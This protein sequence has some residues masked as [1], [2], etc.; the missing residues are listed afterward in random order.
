MPRRSPSWPLVWGLTTAALFFAPV[1]MA[2]KSTSQPDSR[3]KASG[4]RPLHRLDSTHL[5]AGRVNPLGLALIS[6]F[7]YQL[8]LYEATEAATRDN[9]VGIGINPTISPATY[10]IGAFLELQPLSVLQLFV[11]YELIG[12]T[13]SFDFLQSFPGVTSEFSDDT[14]DQLA[15]QDGLPGDNYG[16][17]GTQLTFGG[18]LQAKFGPVAF[19]DGFRLGYVD[20]DLREGDRTYYDTAYDVLAADE[21]WLMTNDLD[22]LWVTD[23][24]LV[25]GARWTMTHVFYESKHYAEGE[26]VGD[27]PNTPHHRFGPL[28]AYTFW[29]DGGQSAFD[30]P[31]VLVLV[32]WWLE[33]RYRTGVEQSQALPY[34]VLGFSFTGDLLQ[35]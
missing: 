33:H 23:I 35:L 32:N 34:M 25:A 5:V 1:A 20:M 9:Y 3:P 13:G 12:Y 4:T 29:D 7:S 19:R 27:N 24:G 17:T 18:L 15:S 22:L 16:P 26:T 6:R 30:R 8:R 21:G 2:Q 31:T 28:I 10:R 11:N 14:L